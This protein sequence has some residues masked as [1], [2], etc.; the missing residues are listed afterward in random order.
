MPTKWAIGPVHWSVRPCWYLG[1]GKS[2]L[3]LLVI[4]IVVAAL[5][6]CARVGNLHDQVPV[7]RLSALPKSKKNVLLV[8]MRFKDGNPQQAREVA[9]S[10]GGS[11]WE[12]VL[13]E[14][15]HP[16]CNYC[17]CT[18]AVEKKGRSRRAGSDTFVVNK[19]KR[20]KGDVPT[21]AEAV[22][23]MLLQ[24]TFGPTKGE[25]DAVLKNVSLPL[26]R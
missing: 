6:F 22:A 11:P 19:H 25:I 23:R 14:P 15:L 2:H 21:E 12:G 7:G 4:T 13:P 16:T 17:W 3:F 5:F 24:G 26:T 18:I 1:H 8:L 9:R 20:G 10:Y